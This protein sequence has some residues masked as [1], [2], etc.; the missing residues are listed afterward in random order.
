MSFPLLGSS[1]V[2][3]SSRRR[4]TVASL[5]VSV[6]STANSVASITTSP[7]VS[8]GSPPPSPPGVSAAASVTELPAPSR[9]VSVAVTDPV[10]PD[11]SAVKRPCLAR[12]G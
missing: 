2:V 12:R 3:G 4:I 11:R 8:P 9:T 1:W 6:L 10:R 7:P 5:L